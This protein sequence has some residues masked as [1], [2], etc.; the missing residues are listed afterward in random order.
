ML[1]LF[2]VLV[3]NLG[4]SVLCDIRGA[5]SIYMININSSHLELSFFGRASCLLL[6]RVLGSYLCTF[7]YGLGLLASLVVAQKLA[8]TCDTSYKPNSKFAIEN[9]HLGHRFPLLDDSYFQW[10]WGVFW[11]MSDTRLVDIFS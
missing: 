11:L 4:W 2:N 5:F 6:K 8:A 1:F 3:A 10:F 9:I 7:N